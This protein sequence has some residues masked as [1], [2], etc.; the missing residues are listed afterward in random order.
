MNIQAFYNIFTVSGEYYA[1]ALA[2]CGLQTTPLCDECE[3]NNYIPITSPF[4]YSIEGLRLGDIMTLWYSYYLVSEKVCRLFEENNVTGVTFH[5]D[6]K[7][8]DWHDRKGK[9]VDKPFPKYVY[10]TIDSHCG[11]VIL[12]NGK[13]FPHCKK[14]G[15]ILNINVLGVKDA[16][17]IDRWDGSDIFAYD[18][19]CAAMCTE[20]VKN[21]VEI[22]KLKNFDFKRARCTSKF[23][24]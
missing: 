14:C 8:I 11:E 15:N 18:G 20:R 10:M 13:R 16:F 12:N 22:N 6:V 23:K 19:S 5:A 24:K 9:K 17:N 1:N 2:E 7:C 3:K 4:N 21:I